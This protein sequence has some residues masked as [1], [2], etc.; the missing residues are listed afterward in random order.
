MLHSL[1]KLVIIFFNKKCHLCPVKNITLKY[2]GILSQNVTLSSKT[3]DKTFFLVQNIMLKYN[4]VSHQNATFS[5]EIRDKTFFKENINFCYVLW[6]SAHI[7]WM[8]KIK[9]QSFLIRLKSQFCC[10][11]S[12]FNRRFVMNYVIFHTKHT[13]F[14]SA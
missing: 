2:H 11:T 4:D 9:R 10:K 12:R 8:S 7:V 6:K 1:Q 13:T 3:L 5:W 14:F